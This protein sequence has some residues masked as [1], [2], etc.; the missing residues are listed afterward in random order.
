MDFPVYETELEISIFDH[1]RPIHAVLNSL[2]QLIERIACYIEKFNKA[3]EAVKGN[4]AV[5]AVKVNI[6]TVFCN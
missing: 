6:K 4:K 3:V 2:I 5:E 1:L